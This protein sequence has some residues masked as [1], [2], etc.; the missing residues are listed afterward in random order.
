MYFPIEVI[1]ELKRQGKPT[2][3]LEQC[4]LNKKYQG[5]LNTDSTAVNIYD[6]KISPPL[7]ELTPVESLQ[8][9]IFGR[10]L[11]NKEY[12]LHQK[13]QTFLYVKHRDRLKNL[14]D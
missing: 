9:E 10:V 5:K 3:Y 14:D 2:W 4:N 11:T 12:R 13:Q 7:T 8:F 6:E 1:N